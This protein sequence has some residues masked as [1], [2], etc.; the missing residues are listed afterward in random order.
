MKTVALDC[1]VSDARYVAEINALGL[2]RTQAFGRG[3]TEGSYEECSRDKKDE[4]DVAELGAVTGGIKGALEEFA[5]KTK[6]RL[7]RKIQPALPS[8]VDTSTTATRSAT[9]IGRFWGWGNAVA[10]R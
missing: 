8:A 7:V 1:V 4:L 10:A 3:C 6:Q 5:V 2:D 9:P